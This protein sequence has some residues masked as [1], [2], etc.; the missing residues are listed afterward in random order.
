[1]GH[2][3]DEIL[4]SLAENGN[5]AQFVSYDPKGNQRFS[6][7]NGFQTN[8][9]FASIEESVKILFDKAQD[10]EL[11]IRS[12]KPDDPKG[13]P[14]IRH[15]TTVK[16]TVAKA[17]E[18]LEQGLFII[19]HEEVEDAGKTSGV[20]LGNVIEFAPLTTPRCVEL[21]E[22]DKQGFAA[23]LPKNIAL[24]FF[25]KIYGFIP[26]LNFPDDMRVEFSLLPKPYGHKQDHVMTWELENVGNTKTVASWDWPN[27]FSKFIG[28]KTYGLLIADVLGLLVPRTQ[29][30]GREVF[31]VF[32]TPTGS[33]VKWT[34]TAPAEQTPGKFT[35][36]RGYVDPF[37]LLKKEDENKAI[38]AVLV[39]DEVPFEYSGTVSIKSDNSLLIEGVKGQG[40]NFMLGKQSPDD[41]P[42]TVVQALEK[43]CYQ[44]K[45]ILGPVRMEWVFDGKQAWVVQLHKC[46]VQSK[47]DVIVPGNPEKWK[48]FVLTED[49][50]LEE[51]R[52]FSE[53]AKQGGFGVE[54]V[55]NFGLTSH[56]GDIL[57][58]ANVPAK[59]VKLKS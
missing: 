21:A 54:V 37:E 55:G 3:K 39:Q 51:L 52:K 57:R 59:R 16:E 2:F 34:R 5:I 15:L 22:T 18:M 14:F 23:S 48:Q 10:G 40:D 13:Q 36:I 41:L 31:F 35:T 32:G 50:G 44:A 42:E 1:L 43:L 53:Q 30:I 49:K 4:I 25:E 27:R 8:H 7:V 58:K 47:D 56:V 26:S 11:E 12:F 24:K 45:N 17:K 28:D 38:A 33:A 9:K 46:E 29:V 20:L 6:C 19:I